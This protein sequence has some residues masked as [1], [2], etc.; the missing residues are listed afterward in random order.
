MPMKVGEPTR[1]RRGELEIPVTLG[2]PV[3]LMT[4]DIL[5]DRL[6]IALHD[7]AMAKRAAT[8]S[9]AVRARNGAD[10]AVAHLERLGVEQS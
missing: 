2:L 9:P 3:D 8:L 5:T 4:A 7:P 1:S 6:D 10:A